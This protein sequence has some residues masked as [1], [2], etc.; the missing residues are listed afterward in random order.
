MS[1]VSGRSTISRS[2][3]RNAFDFRHH[4]R[5]EHSIDHRTAHQRCRYVLALPP[6]GGEI[7]A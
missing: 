7:E 4:D 6:E 2:V 3:E 5:G 1:A